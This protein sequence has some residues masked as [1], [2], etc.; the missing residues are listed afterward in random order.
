MNT[1]LENI[2]SKLAE[3]QNRIKTEGITDNAGNI[4]VKPTTGGVGSIK[5]TLTGG[6]TEGLGDKVDNLTAM[7]VL[8]RN[9]SNKFY[10]GGV[11]KGVSTGMAWLQEHGYDTTKMAGG[12][13]GRIIDMVEGQVA[14]QTET[15]F[16]NM[17]DILSSI[18]KNQDNTK[19]TAQDTISR[20]VSM[21][22][23]NGLSKEERN[24]LW[25]A[26]G[27]PGDAIVTAEKG[28]T[29]EDIRKDILSS[30]DGFYSQYENAKDPEAFRKNVVKA[31]TSTYGKEM[32]GYIEQV[33]GALMPEIVSKGLKI[34]DLDSDTQLMIRQINFQLKNNGEVVD[35]T[36]G[37]ALGYDEIIRRYPQ[38]QQFFEVPESNSIIK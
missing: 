9:I 32:S 23:W 26:A 10:G 25:T 2:K 29:A 7:R 6:L 37:E 13:T 20:M 14:S 3:L 22:A 18:S 4:L 34:E 12:V 38:W 35:E 1:Q 5:N 31:L 8:M 11:S 21:G 28:E 16:Q 36:T 33:V 24:Q 19:N 30:V 15:Q 17:S 27:Y